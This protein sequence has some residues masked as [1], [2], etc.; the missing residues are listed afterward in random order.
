MSGTS[1]NESRWRNNASC[2]SG[3]ASG[4]RND[5][6]PAPQGSWRNG[7]SGVSSSASGERNDVRPATQGNWRNGG[8]GVSS[9]ASGER[10]DVR[11]ASQ[12]SWRNGGSGVSSSA[13]GERND[14]R[15]APQGSWRNGGSGVSSSASGER[16]DVGPATQGSWRNG[17]SGIY[18]SA[19][20]GWNNV[21]P[22]AE[23]GAGLAV[24]PTRTPKFSEVTGAPM[25]NLD[26]RRKGSSPHSKANE[27][28]GSRTSSAFCTPPPPPPRCDHCKQN[29]H[30]AEDCKDKKLLVR[31]MNNEEDSNRMNISAFSSDKRLILSVITCEDTEYYIVHYDPNNGKGRK[32]RV[33]ESYAIVPVPLHVNDDDA[34]TVASHRRLIDA[35]F[36]GGRSSRVGSYNSEDLV[37]A[38]LREERF[39]RMVERNDIRPKNIRLT[40][41]F[42]D[43]HD[44]DT[45]AV[46]VVGSKE[47]LTALCVEYNSIRPDFP[48]ITYSEGDK[49]SALLYISFKDIDRMR[50]SKAAE[51][52]AIFERCLRKFEHINQSSVPDRKCSLSINMKSLI[53]DRA[54]T[55]KRCELGDG[56][57]VGVSHYVDKLVGNPL[58]GKRTLCETP[59]QC[60]LREALEEGDLKIADNPLYRP[61]WHQQK[62]INL[63]YY[64]YGV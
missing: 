9:S 64:Y 63:Y 7:G 43:S 20:G 18:S 44:M 23:S 6:R 34:E 41:G 39:G 42:V 50:A 17:A 12:G 13:S 61:V 38:L 14:V 10:N 15:P 40:K 30:L 47:N 32:K 55:Q 4:E 21:H 1:H 11:P 19:S 36:F 57:I 60:A 5:V 33:P 46:V 45:S 8:S 59:L 24:I 31:Y 49:S 25:K 51:A 2:G 29:N 27:Q 56:V 3:S 54:I 37:T 28:N 22:A 52:N 35:N 48:I 53:R 26:G 58:G 16:N 62:E